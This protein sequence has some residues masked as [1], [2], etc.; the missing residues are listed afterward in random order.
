MDSVCNKLPTSNIG[1]PA[2][3]LAIVDA[4]AFSDDYKEPIFKKK[5]K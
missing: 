3:D 5:S 4:S 2:A 1:S